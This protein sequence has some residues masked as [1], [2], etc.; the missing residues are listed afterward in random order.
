M[1][2]Q[3]A[4]I[5]NHRWL[6]GQADNVVGN[7]EPWYN[8]ISLGDSGT[9]IAADGGS[10]YRG[11]SFFGR[12]GY[13]YDDRYFASVTFRRDGTSKYQQH[14]GNFPSIGLGWA[15]S[16]EGFMKNQRVFDYLKLRASWGLLGNDKQAVSDG[17]AGTGINQV[18]MDNILYSGYY[19]NNTFSWLLWEKVDEWNAGINNTG[20]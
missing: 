19:L 7:G 11:L 10:T 17:F 2:G 20:L 12:A 6:Q 1:A 3:S 14:W 16:E 13:S 5:E 8:Y 18:A 15:L 4:R 9:R